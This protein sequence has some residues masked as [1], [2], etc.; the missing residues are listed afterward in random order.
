MNDDA[1]KPRRADVFPPDYE[2][3]QAANNDNYEDD[4]DSGGPGCLVWGVMGVFGIVIAI[5]IVLTAI[6]AGFNEGLNTAR[7]TAAVSTQRIV[8]GQCAIMPT[9]IAAGS[10]ERL[11]SRFESMT[12]DGVL[13][14]CAQAFVQ[15]ATIVYEQSLITPTQAATATATEAPTLEATQVVEVTTTAVATAEVVGTDSP[16]DLDALLVEARDFMAI[17]DYGEAI[18]TLDAI[19][20][21]DPN[22]ETQTINGLL[23]NA[24]TQRALFLYRSEGGSLAEAI[25]LTTRAEQFGSIQSTELPFERSVAELYLDAQANLGL[26]YQLSISYLNQ[27]I[28]YSPN[29]PRGT[30]GAGSQLVQQYIAYGD[31]LLAGGDA[32]TAEIQFNTAL[33]FRPNN[34]ELQNKAS[35]ANQQCTFGA[36]A[37]VDPNA[38]V[39]PNATLAPTATATS[40]VAPIG[41]N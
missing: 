2:F 6:L 37:T 5:A 3:E 21:I 25:L 12:F 30:G 16:Y 29:Y 35:T 39:N 11:E 9:D 27:V 20:N 23:F 41:Q 22:F 15:Q 13:A 28:G 7:V 36:P 40:G 32:C 24:L 10:F 18:V 4:E 34:L 17:S 1:T 38:T 8:A 14:D 31:S 26:N 33:S 19:R